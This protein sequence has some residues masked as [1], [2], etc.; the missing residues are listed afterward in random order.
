MLIMILYAY[1]SITLSFAL[2]D[3]VLGYID[4]QRYMTRS[5][6]P[7]HRTQFKYLQVVKYV[8]F[9][10]FLLPIWIVNTRWQRIRLWLRKDD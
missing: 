2:C 7:S 8:A 4:Y 6:G 9:F 3:V 5:F 1:L 10:P